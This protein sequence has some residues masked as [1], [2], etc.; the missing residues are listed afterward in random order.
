MRLFMTNP[1]IKFTKRHKNCMKYTKNIYEKHEKSYDK[2]IK[3]DFCDI[4]IS[5]KKE[6]IEEEKQTAPYLTDT[7]LAV[8]LID[9]LL[10]KSI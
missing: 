6:A 5:A 3:R 10:G 8:C 7:N 2:D 4:L 1:F 9:I